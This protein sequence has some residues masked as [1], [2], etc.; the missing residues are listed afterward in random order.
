MKF[1][2]GAMIVP[3][4]AFNSGLSLSLDYKHIYPSFSG[5]ISSIF[6]GYCTVIKFLICSSLVIL[7]HAAFIHCF[8]V[9]FVFIVFVF[10]HSS[11]LS[12]F[13]AR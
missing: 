10:F 11:R 3:L 9:S 13:L 7:L 12:N 1:L 4:L 8:V 5:L 6:F 2:F